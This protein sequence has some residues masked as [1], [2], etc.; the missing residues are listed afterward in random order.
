MII[1]EDKKSVIKF[2]EFRVEESCLAKY[3]KKSDLIRIT[4]QSL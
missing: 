4:K 1:L 2:I 3:N